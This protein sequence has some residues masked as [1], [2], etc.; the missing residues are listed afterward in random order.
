MKTKQRLFVTFLMAMSMGLQ[1]MATPVQDDFYIIWDYNLYIAGKKLVI[2]SDGDSGHYDNYNDYCDDLSLGGGTAEISGGGLSGELVIKLTNVTINSPKA[3]YI[4]DDFIHYTEKLTVEFYGTNRI[5]SSG[6][7]ITCKSAE[8]TFKVMS[9]TTTIE[10]TGSDAMYMETAKCYLETAPDASLQILASQVAIKGNDDN[11][12]SRLYF[13]GGNFFIKGNAGDL[14]SL[15]TVGDRSYGADQV[16][17]LYSTNYSYQGINIPLPIVNNVKSFNFTSID[18]TYYFINEGNLIRSTAIM[19]PNVRFDKTE[20]KLVD[21]A[22]MVSY[23][24]VL[25]N[26]YVAAVNKNFFPDTNLRQYIK[27]EFGDFIY[28]EQVEE[29]DELNIEDLEI[30]DL[31]GI[32]YFT[33]LATLNFDGNYN[34]KT[35]DVSNNKKLIGISCYKNQIKGA[36]MDNFVNSLPTVTTGELYV[37]YCEDLSYPDGNEMTPQQVTKAKKKGWTVYVYDNYSTNGSNNTHWSTTDGF[38]LINRDRFPDAQFRKVLNDMDFRCK[39]ALTQEDINAT[40]EMM[41]FG[42][43]IMDMTGIEYFTKLT[44]LDITRNMFVNNGI[45]LSQNK[46]LKNLYIECNNISGSNMDNLVDKLPSVRSGE[47]TVYDGRGDWPET[48]EMTP[49][50]V[51]KAQQKGWTVKVF[52]DKENDTWVETNGF[53]LYSATRF[54]DSYFRNYLIEIK[55]WPSTG[56]IRAESAE[57]TDKIYC[58]GKN[59]SSLVGLEYFPNIKELSFYG[60]N[61]EEIDLSGFGNLYLVV[62]WANNIKGSSM[63]KM[64]NSLP[65]MPE[66]KQGTLRVINRHNSSYTEGNEITVNQVATAK[67]KRWI[68]YE[69]NG[70]TWVEYTGSESGITTGLEALPL[71]DN[72]EMINDKARESW[73]T[74]DGRKLSGK[75][76]KKGIYIRNGKAVVN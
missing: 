63:S 34:I 9:G 24:V 18:D 10:S 31:T 49:A 66:G 74:I 41:A 37:Y 52:D 45:D 32:E 25:R 21:G 23:E 61:I 5:Y 39:G 76:T 27:D 62:C 47:I 55:S 59:I 60:N 46:K 69:Y 1:V 33:E 53:W 70:S 57:A 67:A 7:P 42:Y 50:Q 40:D 36:N 13:C 65:T 48:N 43:N 75:P 14:T 20:K 56:A 54:P 30:A 4:D 17:D 38:Y 26:D 35:V 73:Y 64:I 2:C 72:G 58:N 6:Q 68:P 11:N 28:K 19:D 8:T 15:E 51:A 3:I 29:T 44:T 16:I 71:N 22:G 12:Y